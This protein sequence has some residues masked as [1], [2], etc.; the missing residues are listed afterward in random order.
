[1][2][3]TSTN[4]T[5]S[6]NPSIFLPCAPGEGHAPRAPANHQHQG[7]G[8]SPRHGPVLPPNLPLPHTGHTVNR[9]K[10]GAQHTGPTRSP[11]TTGLLCQAQ[12]AASCRIPRHQN[13]SSRTLLS[14][15]GGQGIRAPLEPTCIS[16]ENMKHHGTRSQGTHSGN[17]RA[18]SAH[19][20]CEN[21]ARDTF[22]AALKAIRVREREGG[23]HTHPYFFISSGPFPTTR[24]GPRAHRTGPTS[25]PAPVGEHGSVT[26]GPARRAVRDTRIPEHKPGSPSLRKPH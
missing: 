15:A 17:T 23:L 5:N 1:M 9:T 7:R 22:P 2:F 8:R 24:N 19:V 3:S 4:P 18:T 13:T 20:T 25:P 14:R 26:P 10:G 16:S 11:M 12:P 21:V 6:P